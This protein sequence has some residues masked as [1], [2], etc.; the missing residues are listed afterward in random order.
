M[1]GEAAREPGSRMPEVSAQLD[2]PAMEREMLARWSRART[3]DHS[4]EQTAGGP[5]WTFYE[6]PPTANGMPGIHHVEARVFKDVFPRFKTMQGFYVQRQA[7]WD[8]HGLPVEVAVERG[9]GISG[10]KDIE[11]YRITEFNQRCRESVLCH[12]EAL[13]T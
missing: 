2:L 12:V 8:C 10:K 11:A 6:G 9:L 7:G 5:R 4:L 1:S 3:F 13:R